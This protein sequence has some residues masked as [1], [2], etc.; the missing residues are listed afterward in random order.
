MTIAPIFRD[1]ISL[2]E[3]VKL[4][5]T[6]ITFTFKGEPSDSS[7]AI[8]CA[9]KLLAKQKD[10]IEQLKAENERLEAENK[11][12]KSDILSFEYQNF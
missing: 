9:A 11:D 2:E 1:N 12:L 8:E 4:L 6:F 3:Q 10:Q 5:A 7:G